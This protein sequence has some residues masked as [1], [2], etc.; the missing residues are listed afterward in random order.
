MPQLSLSYYTVG[1]TTREGPSLVKLDRNP[2]S[3]EVGG[4]SIVPI[5]TLCTLKNG[6]EDVVEVVLTTTDAG[7]VPKPLH[8]L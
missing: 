5:Y 6:A 2:A 3:I 1:V 7:V 4:E 8:S